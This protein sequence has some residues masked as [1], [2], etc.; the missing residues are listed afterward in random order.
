MRINGGE[1][2]GMKQHIK[3]LTEML[4]A[5][6]PKGSIRIQ[7]SRRGEATIPLTDDLSVTIETPFQVE[8]SLHGNQVSLTFPNPP[9]GHYSFFDRFIDAVHLQPHRVDVEISG[10]LIHPDVYMTVVS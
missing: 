3:S 8:Y 9:T 1:L 6:G 5:L 4:S 7:S 10:G 2:H